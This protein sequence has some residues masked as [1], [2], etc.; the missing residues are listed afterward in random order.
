MRVSMLTADKS[1]AK[2]SAEIEQFTAEYECKNGPVKTIGIINRGITPANWNRTIVTEKK[3][4][5]TNANTATNKQVLLHYATAPCLKELAA[6]LGI[7]VNS[8]TKRAGRLGASRDMKTKVE[9]NPASVRAAK[10]MSKAAEMLS[11]GQ[12][13]ENVAEQLDIS[14]RQVRY[15]RKQLEEMQEAA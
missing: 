12:S 4:K 1:L 15:Y 7:T 13:P 8:L 2:L 11:D 9:K 3:V 14:P 10:R 6:K 5:R